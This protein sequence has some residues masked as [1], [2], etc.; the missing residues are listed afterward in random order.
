[1]GLFGSRPAAELAA[2]QAFSQQQAL[3]LASGERPSL[4][5]SISSDA[6]KVWQLAPIDSD[7]C[8]LE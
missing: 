8:V 1:M 6:Y 3:T 5:E 2:M 4:S 7:F